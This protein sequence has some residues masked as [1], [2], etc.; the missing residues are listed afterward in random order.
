MNREEH[1]LT[2]LGEEC[3]ELIQEAS[4]AKR[5]GID[6]QRDLSTSNRERMQKEFNDVLAMIEMLNDF[7]RDNVFSTDATLIRLKKIKV[8]KYLQY[9]KECGTLGN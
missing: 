8:E 5:F 6:E 2:I 1:L 4:K 9:S 3:A 7:Y